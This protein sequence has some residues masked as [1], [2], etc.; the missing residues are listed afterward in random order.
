[1]TFQF[2]KTIR[3]AT[4][5]TIGAAAIVT[6]A[7]EAAPIDLE[8]LGLIEGDTAYQADV[9]ID[10]VAGTDVFQAVDM[11]FEAIFDGNPLATN[12]IVEV[13][14]DFAIAFT[15]TGTRLGT[16]PGL[17]E[18]LATVDLAEGAFAGIT[19]RVLARVTGDGLDLGGDLSALP[20]TLTILEV[21]PIPAPAAGW[22]L[23]A[24]MGLLIA[25]RRRTG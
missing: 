10:Y 24:G 8:A 23:L 19:D 14:P 20:G 6:G 2:P 18:I 11:T 21:A 16:D 15:A 1:M 4:A 12:T 7:A 5:A 25:M 13:A 9:S 3:A 22:A 17:V